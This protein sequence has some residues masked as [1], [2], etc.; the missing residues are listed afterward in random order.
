MW[1]GMFRKLKLSSATQTLGAWLRSPAAAFL[2]PLWEQQYLRPRPSAGGYSLTWQLWLL[3]ESQGR[4]TCCQKLEHQSVSSR[5]GHGYVSARRRAVSGTCLTDAFH[6]QFLKCSYKQI[7]RVYSRP[8][9]A[10]FSSKP[11]SKLCTQNATAIHGAS[12]K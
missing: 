1:M 7:P 5:F 4:K 10:T 6:F 2:S 11:P 3:S 8:P 12:L 9:K